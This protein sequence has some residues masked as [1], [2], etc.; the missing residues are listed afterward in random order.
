M[1]IPAAQPEPGS[2]SVVSVSARDHSATIE[3]IAI[4]AGKPMMPKPPAT[5]DVL[6]TPRVLD[7]RAF[8]ELSET[9]RA[10]I[11]EA[12]QAGEVLAETTR[13][14]AQQAADSASSSKQL[15]ERL[16]LSARMLKAMQAQSA[17]LSS[18]A[19]ATETLEKQCAP[20]EQ[21]LEARM[22][23]L[24]E[25]AETRLEQAVDRAI[26]RLSD[27]AGSQERLLQEVDQRLGELM[28]RAERLGQLVETAEVNIAALSHRSAV[29]IRKA[30]Q[31]ADGLSTLLDRS[32]AQVRSV[33]EEF[34]R[35]GEL[36]AVLEKA[37]SLTNDWRD[38]LTRVE[39]KR[40]SIPSTS[41]FAEPK[42]LADSAANLV[43]QLR[44]SVGKDMQRLSSLV[45]DIAAR[46]EHLQSPQAV[47]SPSD[48]PESKAPQI[49]SLPMP[50]YPATLRSTA[51]DDAP[52]T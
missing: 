24:V 48:P 49:T 13:Q 28:P 38:T 20:F 11:D 17:A 25:G 29:S 22:Q 1:P 19:A 26:T 30:E 12:R 33:H 10:L 14:H 5:N 3:T 34:S 50:R 43:E 31:V 2:Q 36:R 4:E 52:S 23:Q 9:L 21:R 35:V 40:S 46:V 15:Q 41:Q 18:A 32:D 47:A 44:Q 39:E 42:P 45:C 6:I 27:G 51:S 37:A 16:H 7:Q 8:A